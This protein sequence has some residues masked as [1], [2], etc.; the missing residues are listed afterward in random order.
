MHIFMIRHGLTYSNKA[1][2]YSDPHT[3][4][5]PEAAGQLMAPAAYLRQF[6]FSRVLTSDYLRARKTAELLGYPDAQPEARLRERNFGIFTNKTLQEV[7]EVYPEEFSRLTRDSVSYAIPEGES[8]DMV[9]ARV[10]G[11]LDE[12]TRVERETAVAMQGFHPD[13]AS[14]EQIL[15]VTHFN[16]MLAALGWILDTKQVDN[17]LHTHNG[18][19]LEID[20]RGK[21][22]SIC[23]PTLPYIHAE[24]GQA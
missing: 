14:S 7:Q 20:V 18:G 5:A 24:G 8:F 11:L 12:L 21:E 15:L 19:I 4:L 10:W 22:K 17:K 9:C 3:D 13:E 16:V 1:T 23:L 6:Q 2:T